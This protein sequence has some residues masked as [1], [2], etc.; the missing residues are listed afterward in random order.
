MKFWKK[1]NHMRRK[2]LSAKSKFRREVQSVNFHYTTHRLLR[3]HII[4][5]VLET[6]YH[7]RLTFNPFSLP[8]D[9]QFTNLH[10]LL[11][12]LRPS[13]KTRTANINNLFREFSTSMNLNYMQ[14]DFGLTPIDLCID[15][16]WMAVGQEAT[17]QTAS[18][19]Q[20]SL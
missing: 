13:R 15:A 7:L 10:Y 14:G 11:L 9:H 20:S 1:N 6:N 12:K 3:N 8:G 16:V 5:S 2:Y 17:E 19:S 4:C 18:L